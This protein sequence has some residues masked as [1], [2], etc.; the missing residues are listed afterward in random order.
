[1]R[2][3]KVN[4]VINDFQMLANS[5][6]VENRVYDE[7]MDDITTGLN[8][9]QNDESVVNKSKDEEIVPKI[10]S[11]LTLGLNFLNE[12]FNNIGSEVPQMDSDDDEDDQ[13]IEALNSHATK[14][15]FS[16]RLL[17]YIIGSEEFI[18]DNYVGLSCVEENPTIDLKTKV[19]NNVNANSIINSESVESNFNNTFPVRNNFPHENSFIDNENDSEEESGDLFGGLPDRVKATINHKQES[20]DESDSNQFSDKESNKNDSILETSDK[21]KVE[22]KAITSAVPSFHDELSAAISGKKTTRALVDKSQNETNIKIVSNKPKIPISIH[23]ESSDDENDDI[24]RIS[25]N[26][27]KVESKGKSN[28]SNLFDDESNNTSIFDEKS[29]KLNTSNKAVP[30]VS[31]RKPTVNTSNLFNGEDD[32][33]E[34]DL[35]FG[36]V[37]QKITQPK[38]T[39]ID[40]Q[41]DETIFIPK[42][43]PK[44]DKPLVRKDS[45][46]DDDEE[47][48]DLF[49]GISNKTNKTG[50]QNTDTFKP[51]T[52]SSNI[53]IKPNSNLIG[54]LSLALKKKNL[55]PSDDE[56]N[57]SNND[58]VNDIPKN[59]PK[60]MSEP[61]S[62]VINTKISVN[63]NVSNDNIS[64]NS[65]AISKDTKDSSNINNQIS[66][67]VKSNE[68]IPPN[69]DEFSSIKST[70]TL[71]NDSLK[72]RAVLGS[73]RSRRPPSKKVVKLTPITDF[74]QNPKKEA[75]NPLEPEEKSPPI[76]SAREVKPQNK[77]I[78][79]TITSNQNIM[80]SNSSKP[81][82]KSI[83]SLLRSPSTEEEDIFPSH[84]NDFANI[85]KVSIKSETRSHDIFND[86][87]A[88]DD[89]LFNDSVKNKDRN[90]ITRKSIDRN[91]LFDSSESE[92]ELN[93][94]TTNHFD[95][96]KR[97]TNTIS[98]IIKSSK[99]DKDLFNT[100]SST[101]S[102]LSSKSDLK[103]E[104]SKSN[105]NLFDDSD[106]EDLFSTIAKIKPNNKID[107][108]KETKKETKNE[109]K[110]ETKKEIKS[111]TKKETKS[112]TKKEDQKSNRKP[113]KL[114]SLFSDSEDDKIDLFKKVD[115]TKTIKSKT[116][117]TKSLFD[118]ED[119]DEEGI[120]K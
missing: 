10:K 62:E 56:E 77:P 50:V 39:I 46:F 3:V 20:S 51:I 64:I 19:D 31:A 59:I 22:S 94:N 90:E 53:Q 23:S 75:N 100:G 18:K 37:S 24:F 103:V 104:N 109:T 36:A 81:D 66:S 118:N 17:P 79:E 99:G 21:N 111:E 28:F 57:D 33:D 13:I 76:V 110:N 49:S 88:N 91:A 107:L 45:L 12:R 108:Q 95:S 8:A 115:E 117:S 74:S 32:E 85:S 84:T 61:F 63:S 5:Q 30:N 2:C 29:S 114:E 70:V 54:E 52:K 89:S 120:Q 112:E 98:S 40:V 102:S 26:K 43:L 80:K 7:E 1:M 97:D 113:S 86:N 60:V 11:A 6:F 9:V 4:N 71:S 101:D 78:L 14:D 15:E 27:P 68:K 93:S 34:D 119:D 44:S 38:K 83:A 42:E 82:Q 73:K 41:K 25:K 65:S 69:D 96:N 106:G 67:E 116:I 47:E 58:K 55:Y 92:D 105:L 72:Q 16:Q 48:D 35:F 87:D